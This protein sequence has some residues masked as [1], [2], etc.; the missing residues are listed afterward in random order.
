M[1][2]HLDPRETGLIS[3]IVHAIS[4]DA[5]YTDSVEYQHQV[6]MALEYYFVRHKGADHDGFDKSLEQVEDRLSA[7]TSGTAYSRTLDTF[8]MY[9]D[10]LNT[11]ALP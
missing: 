6:Q 10:A 7:A 1:P 4:R 3:R 2:E 8:L 5:R 11:L 9:L